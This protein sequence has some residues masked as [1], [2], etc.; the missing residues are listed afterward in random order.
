VVWR[1]LPCCFVRHI[2]YVSAFTI[3]FFGCILK[4][5]SLCV[6]TVCKVVR[7]QMKY[8][9][10]YMVEYAGLATCV[11]LVFVFLSLTADTRLKAEVER[12][13]MW[14]FTIYTVFTCSYGTTL[15]IFITKCVGDSARSTKSFGGVL[16]SKAW[17]SSRPV[18]PGCVPHWQRQALGPTT[19]WV[20][21]GGGGARQNL[22]HTNPWSL[23]LP[24]F[25]AIFRGFFRGAASGI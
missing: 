22:R 19:V 2:V 15:S 25:T 12:H 16:S 13:E 7:Y 10:A 4:G 20:L 17:Q 9:A 5:V 14:S 1:V 11:I 18:K 21:E 23:S 8:S 6:T 24:Q 3:T